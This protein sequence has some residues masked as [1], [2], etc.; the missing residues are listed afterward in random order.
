MAR[1]KYGI[2]VSLEWAYVVF[3]VNIVHISVTTVHKDVSPIKGDSNGVL[4]VPA[5]RHNIPVG[6]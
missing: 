1:P 3:S 2:Y 5:L 4:Y 6:K